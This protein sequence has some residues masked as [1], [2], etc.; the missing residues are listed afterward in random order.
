MWPPTGGFTLYCSFFI[1]FML[2]D[3][4]KRHI[5]DDLMCDIRDSIL[6]HV[7]NRLHELDDERLDT[8]SYRVDAVQACMD[9]LDTHL[10]VEFKD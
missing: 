6:D 1:L 4:T 7:R 2:I 5:R 8:P 3:Y 9:Y 10:T